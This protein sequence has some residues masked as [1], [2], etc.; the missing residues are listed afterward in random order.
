MNSRAS[1]RFWELFEDLPADVRT[2]ARE[3]FKRFSHDPFHPG[4]QF[5]HV[6]PRQPLWSVRINRNYRALGIRDNDRI[7]WIW[8][9]THAEY[10]HLLK[11]SR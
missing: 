7:T 10:N 6:S 3:A 8:L 2:Q 4:L 5:K 9:G 1:E 11:Q